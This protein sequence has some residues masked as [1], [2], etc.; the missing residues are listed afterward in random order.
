MVRCVLAAMAV[1]AAAAGPAGGD[2]F[3]L[4][5]SDAAVWIVRATEEGSAF[6]VVAR[7]LD[8][9]W[10]W[11]QEKFAGAPSAVAAVERSLHVLLHDP[12]GYV[13]FRARPN[14]FMPG[15]IP[16]GPEWSGE[17][18]PLALLAG[19]RI[20]EIETPS[21][22]AVVPLRT[23]RPLPT[24]APAAEPPSAPDPIAEPAPPPAD[25]AR[26]GE[27]L[28]IPAPDGAAT[29]P[30]D[31]F[32]D[33]DAPADDAAP[34]LRAAQPRLG[35][36]QYT[37]LE[38]R[39]L[40]EVPLDLLPPGGESRILAAST[41]GTLHLLALAPDG[42]A[43]PR[44]LRYSRG[45]WEAAPLPEVLPAGR[46][47]AMLAVKGRL[48][49]AVTAP[50]PEQGRRLLRLA[51]IPV[52]APATQPTTA[53]TDAPAVH[54]AMREG[55]PLTVPADALPRVA[56]FGDAIALL[57]SEGDVLR[58]ATVD[59][60]GALRIQE[61]VQIFH[62]ASGQEQAQQV[63]Q[64]FFW[65]LL[66][67]TFVPLVLLRPKNP[68]G[69]FT[70]PPQFIPASPAR[71][72]VGLLVDMVPAI[73]SGLIW[74]AIFPPPV[75]TMAELAAIWRGEVPLPPAL[76]YTWLVQL[77]FLLVYSIAMEWRFGATL[78]K[79]LVRT[80][81]V[82]DDGKRPDLRGVLLRNLW[83]VIELSL[84]PMMPILPLVIFFNRNRQRVGDWLARTTVVDAAPQPLPPRTPPQLRERT[85]GEPDGPDRENPHHQDTE[86]ETAP[87][88]DAE[89]NLP[90]SD[91]TERGEPSDSPPRS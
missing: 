46:V 91:T 55:R 56:P 59:L 3:F 44:L 71:R 83:K 48:V 62:R 22:L 86:R 61:P 2:E 84:P 65:A 26:E 8:G 79:M 6:D 17:A 18:R 4:A 80:R 38:W 5:G 50:A 51:V 47:I 76:L 13:I 49:F 31:A 20:G 39:V 15:R 52:T 64:G 73:L 85:H 88:T 28:A 41:P 40:T 82:T 66:I 37:G 54:L 58:F 12:F 89:P 78:G 30:A 77:S 36:L 1:C 45:A 57:W 23:Q 19:E 87:P 21:L 72:L 43:A 70:L 25:P 35:I 16:S 33:D 42:S 14:G 74:L 75:L 7:P 68:P 53:P 10:V 29:A 60:S 90:E 63:L 67:G 27:P 9:R 24:T 32:G 34:S 69:P 11:V 81:V